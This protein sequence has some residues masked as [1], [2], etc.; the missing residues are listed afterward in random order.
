VSIRAATPDD[1]VHVASLD[2]ELWEHQTRSPSFS[3]NDVA[4]L[5]EFVDEWRDDTFDSPDTFWP[6]VAERNG[7]VVGGALMYRR[8][9]G[10]LRVPD[11]NVDLAHAATY[12]QHR[13]TGAGLAL[14]AHVIGWAHDQGFRSIT[15]DWR[16]VNLLSSRFWPRRGWRTTYLRLYRAIP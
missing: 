8:P 6:F 11:G 16:S 10:D 7:E 4:P 9:T 14:A 3:N 13:G 1:L 2:R 15:T 12:P 5:D